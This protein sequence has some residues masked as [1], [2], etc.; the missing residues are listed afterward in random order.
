M[1]SYEKMYS[2]DQFMNPGPAP[3]P[4]ADRP[5]LNLPTNP[6]NNVA[7]SFSQMS[8]NSP[9][10]PGPANLSLFPNTST[11]SLTRTKTDQSGGGGVT[12]IKEGYVRCKEDKFLATWNQ[13]Y[14]ILRE[15]RLDF[16]KNE[17]GKIVLSIPLTAVTGVSRSEDTRMAFEIIRLANPKDVNSKTAVITRDVPTKS[18]TCEVKSDDEIYDWID[19]IYERCPGMGGV[20]NPTNF[21]H[22][23]HVGFDPRTGAFVG[24]PPEWEKLLTA[25]AITKEDYKKNPQ[26]V[27]EVLEFYS[28]IK[29]R[30]Q[31]PQYY[32]GLSSPANQ[33]AKPFSGG[34]SVGN[35][36]APP[37]PPPPAPAQR[38]DSGG[39]SYSSQSPVSSPS[40]SKSDSDRALEQQQQLERMNELADK[41]R[42][43][44]E[45]DRRARQRE[46]EQNRLDQEAYNASL[47]KTRVPLA[48]QELGGYGQSPDDRYKPSRPAPQAPGSSRQDP[49]RQLTAQRPA[50]SAPTAGQR[51]GDYANGSA[52]AEQSSPSSRHPA[53]GQ[54]PARA[55]NN[56]VKAQPAQGPPPS[57]LPAPVQ[58]V[59]PLNIANK[60]TAKTNVPDGV[61]QAEAALSKKAEP[62]QREVRMSNMSEN[63]VMDRLRSVVSKDN[64]NESYSKQRKIG[65][66]ASGSV[67]VARVKEHATSG[68]AR[69][70]YRQYGPRTQVAIKQMDLRSQPR[71]ELIV[72]EII[73]M[74]DSQ[75]ANIVNFL[76]SF[77]QEQSN[78]LWV[79]M[80]FMEGGALTDVIDNNP[81]IQEDQIA[82]ICAETCKGLAHLHSQ[83]IIHRDIKSDNVLLDRAGHVKI[84]DFG[85]C[86]KLTESKSKRATMVGTPY[87]MAPEVVKQK[88]YGP[89]VDC[90]SLGIMAIEMIESEPPYLNEEPLKAL[91]LIATNG[92]PRL[93][94]PEKLSK[95]LK[96]FLSVCLCVDVRSRAT[97][98][99]LL[100]H[101]FLKLG[102]SLASLAELLRWKKNSGQ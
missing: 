72:N 75:H 26:A 98:D 90:W 51:P 20:S 48:K 59:K 12:V 66:G 17:T 99:E 19:K 101:D 79:V 41:E 2:P 49:P 58:P 22:R 11:P 89:K 36:I 56:G 30:E 1:A 7:T 87:W 81:V 77:L 78:E 9:S 82:T 38:L 34:G 67:Y 95:E 33:Q 13:R 8:L 14:L 32:A 5:Q 71:K 73:V 45:E 47:P 61:R 62:R 92:T 29:M 91:Y 25:S 94:K 23:V 57:K 88:E 43:R 37:R 52:R 54:S 35:S 46:E 70:L 27:I 42:R 31:N 44:M 3:R 85:F 83:N 80:E 15:F 40:Q 64:P 55:Q 39:Q 96:S 84:T 65:Q 69:E 18:I 28:D 16:L 86:A 100:A 6:S 63:E 76:D 68:V 93:K 24:L 4:P 50:P 74:K 60:Q 97:A 53:Q 10:T 21:S 102:C